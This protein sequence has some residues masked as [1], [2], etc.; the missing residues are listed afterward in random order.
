MLTFNH[1][2]TNILRNCFPGLMHHMATYGP[3]VYT[4]YGSF[5][6]TYY[7]DTTLKYL[8]TLVYFQRQDIYLLYKLILMPSTCL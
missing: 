5:L 3:I 1:I 6:S 7:R 8:H 4:D 2:Q